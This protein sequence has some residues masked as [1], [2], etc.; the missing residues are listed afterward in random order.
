MPAENLRAVES[1][2][3]FGDNWASY[4]SSIDEEAI[5]EAERGILR[6]IPREELAAR[7]FLDIGCGSGI[8]A[9][10]AARLGAQR[11]LAVDIDPR[12][13]ETARALLSAHAPLARWGAETISVFD[14][15]PAEVGT[16]DVVY[17]WGVL[18]HT[19]DLDGAMRRAA[20]LVAPGGLFAFAL[21]R[22]TYL[23]RFWVAEKRWYR[24][25]SPGAQRLAQS[26]YTGLFKA[27]L[28]ATGRSFAAYAAKKK[29]ER[30]MDFAHDVR[31]WLGG[32]PYETI[33][34]EE[35]ERL[36]REL[37]FSEVRRFARKKRELGLFGSGCDE[38]VYRKR[39]TT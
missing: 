37:N 21:Y 36:M 28:A 12:S 31:D 11:I 10:A 24:S 15:D 32:Y 38:Y 33:A 30:G 1:H 16:F 23:D 29:T 35:V 25:A 22:A 7:N 26:L 6:L 14:L 20:A 5:A 34:P 9:L 8:H 19:G 2:F 17:S 3:R 13:V 27:A 39:A 4:A 18:H